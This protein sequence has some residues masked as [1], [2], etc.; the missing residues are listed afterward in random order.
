MSSITDPDKTIALHVGP[1]TTYGGVEGWLPC[2]AP[3]AAYSYK[4]EGG[5]YEA[6]TGFKFNHTSN[7]GAKFIR[8]E[9]N[10]VGDPIHV[11]SATYNITA[12]DVTQDV[13]VP[14]A[15]DQLQKMT[16]GNNFQ[17]IKD[18][19]QI[20]AAGEITI[21]VTEISSGVTGIACDPRWD[22]D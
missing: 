4:Y 19:N 21:T 20:A 12:T 15:A 16:G 1:T 8:F 10:S 18:L 5:N 17:V 13:Q 7:P 11:T 14:P 9:L 6:G 3:N 2:P 22:N